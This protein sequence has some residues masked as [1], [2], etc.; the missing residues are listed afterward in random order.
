MA[1]KGNRTINP[2]DAHRKLQ[3]K[4][5]LK[6]NKKDREKTRLVAAAKK[7]TRKLFEE[8]R[9]YAAQETLDPAQR[10]QKQ[11]AEEKL[12][13]INESRKELGLP[14][15][16]PNAPELKQKKR[17]E[18]EMKWYHPTFNPHGPKKPA[19]QAETSDDSDSSDSGSESEGDSASDSD[20]AGDAKPAQSEATPKEPQKML[21]FD[22]LS[23]IPMPAG[24]GLNSEAQIYHTLE[25]PEIRNKADYMPSAAQANATPQ[26]PAQV[27]PPFMPYG[28]PP[29][30]F[31]GPPPPMGAHYGPPMPFPGPPPFMR[32]PMGFPPGPPGPPPGPPPGRPPGPPAGPPPF[33]FRPPP[34]APGHIGFPMRPP[35]PPGP[36]PPHMLPPSG[37][38]RPPL[39]RAPPAP[40]M[41]Y[42]APPQHSADPSSVSPP[43]AAPAQEA[44]AVIAAAPVV[45][46]L[47]SESARF[48]P[49]ALRRKK[50][51]AA[52]APHSRPA[53]KAA[54]APQ[55]KPRVDAAPD[56][57]DDEADGNP[58]RP[59]PAPKTP[60]K[61]PAPASQKRANDEY[62]EFMNSMKDL[63]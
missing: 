34:G 11:R 1:K 23:Y 59:V 20:A 39:P 48:V 21:D 28:M 52:V 55:T 61:K 45:R 16:D 38:M 35:G 53:A 3:R 57:V 26:P 7:D 40:H 8:I 49:A 30:F 6:K 43:T 51:A 9:G 50:A 60:A 33:G 56:V 27:P 41:H 25:L 29:P 44:P 4:Q 17:E 18:P 12:K 36:P 13:K 58:A 54:R 2:A 22:D 19:R 10:Q 63:L 14:P 15:V 47:Q 37:V 24:A 42:Y 31:P 32:P 5:E 62:E 46:D